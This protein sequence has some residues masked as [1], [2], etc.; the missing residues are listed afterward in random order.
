[1]KSKFRFF[2]FVALMSVAAFTVQSCAKDYSDEIDDLQ[3]QIVAA[4]A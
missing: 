2:G 3:A 1:M 4:Q